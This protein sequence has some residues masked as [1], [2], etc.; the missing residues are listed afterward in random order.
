MSEVVT[1]DGLDIEVDGVEVGSYGR[2]AC[3]LGA[4]DYGTGLAEPRFSGVVVGLA[5]KEIGRAHV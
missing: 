4:Y 1:A 3:A 2:R 5:S